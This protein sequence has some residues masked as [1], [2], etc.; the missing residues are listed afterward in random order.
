M[1]ILIER[2]TRVDDGS[3]VNPESDR[4]YII[5]SAI[6]TGAQGAP[7]DAELV[8][9]AL[10]RLFEAEADS[11]APHRWF[12]PERAQHMLTELD[13][14]PDGVDNEALE[15]I[16]S[17][18]SA[19]STMSAESLKLALSLSNELTENVIKIRW[20][21]DEGTQ[22][23]FSEYASEDDEKQSE[24][25]VGL[26][27][28]SGF[29]SDYFTLM[30]MIAQ[31]QKGKGFDDTDHGEEEEDAANEE[32]R[33]EGFFGDDDF[34]DSNEIANL[35]FSMAQIASEDITFRK[36]LE[37]ALGTTSLVIEDFEKWVGAEFVGEDEGDDQEEEEDEDSE[38]DDV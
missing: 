36:T 20:W 14:I 35:C 33:G 27:V 12:Q 29:L 26:S 9:R 1:D 13:S 11:G 2:T 10:S 25:I 38:S 32:E 8:N 19:D 34:D 17:Q 16:L 18:K 37:I 22:A 23:L 15:A 7:F 24:V 28:L 6:R 3:M 21:L 31:E 4:R 30:E 5:D